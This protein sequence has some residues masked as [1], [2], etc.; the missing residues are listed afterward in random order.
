MP[1]NGSKLHVERY[2]SEVIARIYWV[3][4]F[5]VNYLRDERALGNLMMSLTALVTWH[6]PTLFPRRAA[7]LL[8]RYKE[9]IDRGY[10][11]NSSRFPRAIC[12]VPFVFLI[13]RVE[14]FNVH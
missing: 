14:Q 8:E 1:P 4:F 9:V 12:A 11:S 13:A 10:I 5:T 6:R 3:V 7:W 2:V